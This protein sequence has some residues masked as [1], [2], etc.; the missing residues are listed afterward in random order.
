MT[1]DEQSSMRRAGMSRRHFSM[2]L[3]G[4]VAGAF[5]LPTFVSRSYAQPAAY[6]EAPMLA[7]RVAKGE[8][9]P[10]EE[11]LPREPLVETAYQRNRRLWWPFERRRHG[12][13]NHQ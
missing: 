9:P 1:K 8:L 6:K 4:T 3:S 12:A 5:A 7:E 11:R 2:L 13:G 10:V